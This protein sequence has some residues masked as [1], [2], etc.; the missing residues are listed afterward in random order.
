MESICGTKDTAFGARKAAIKA[1]IVKQAF[2]CFQLV[3]C[4]KCNTVNVEISPRDYASAVRIDET[5]VEKSR[6]SAADQI[7]NDLLMYFKR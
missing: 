2:G 1:K 6:T 3:V 7:G 4:K 5:K